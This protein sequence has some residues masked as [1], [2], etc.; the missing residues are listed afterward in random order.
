MY[1]NFYIILLDGSSVRDM[2][3]NPING[4]DEDFTD[5]VGDIV[6]DKIEAESLNDA[7]KLIAEEYGIKE[8]KLYG[9]Q[10]I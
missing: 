9:Y 5:W 4:R 10:I 8:E 1:N 7:I 2:Q 3:I 6:I